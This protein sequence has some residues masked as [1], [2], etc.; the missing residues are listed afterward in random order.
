[1]S[2]FQKII[3]PVLISLLLTGTLCSQSVDIPDT[4][5]LE[6]LVDLGV[7][8]SNDGNISQEEALRVVS[9]ELNSR[10]ISDLRGL[11]FFTNLKYLSANENKLGFLDVSANTKLETIFCL[12]NSMD[13]LI[14]GELPA[15]SILNCSENNLSLLDVSGCPQIYNLSCWENALSELDITKNGQLTELLFY[16]NQISSIDLSANPL[17][18]FLSSEDNQLTQLDLSNNPVL[19]LIACHGNKLSS[20][21]TSS[22]PLLVELGCEQN[23]LKSLNLNSNPLLYFLSCDDN[24]LSNLNLDQ[25]PELRYLSCIRNNLNSLNLSSNTKLET[26]YCQD[27]NLSFLD[28]ENTII[29]DLNASGN[30]LGEL[31]LR[32][33]NSSAGVNFRIKLREMPM[34]NSVCVWESFPQRDDGMVAEVD[35]G[36][37]PNAELLSNCDAVGKNDQK[38]TGE[39]DFLKVYPNPV[40]DFLNVEFDMD[41]GYRISLISM[42]GYLL[43]SEQ[44]D[45]GGSRLDLRKFSEGAYL[46]R[47]FTSDETYIRRIIVRK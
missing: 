9:L 18:S 27:N 44:G 11:E 28:L 46:L 39:R 19:N 13:T 35:T 37:S 8:T 40:R 33:M 41:Q 30:Q 12:Q 10:G 23:Q 7:D 6:A 45:G 21:S 20:L 32:P 38:I 26:L 1:M 29:H 14:L 25:N 24:E 4:A 43:L 22:N 42:S 16:S 3:F 47:I 2:I 5:F 34:L 15:L 31:D 17:L 36:G